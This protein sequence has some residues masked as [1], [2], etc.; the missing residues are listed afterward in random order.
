MNILI[1]SA[2]T[3]EILPLL[4]YL[5]EHFKSKEGV[6]FFNNKIDIR[7][8]VT[9][10]GAVHTSFHTATFLSK[11]QTDLAINLGIAGALD[12]QLQLGE[13]V[14]IISDQMADIGVE[15]ADGSFS[16]IFDMELQEP[17]EFPYQKGKISPIQAA[18]SFLK[19]VEGITVNKVHGTAASIDQ[20]K[21]KY[22]T[23][24]TESMEGAAFAFACQMN[25]IDYLQIRSIS[26]YVEPRNKANWDIPLAIEALNQVAIELIET[27]QEN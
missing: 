3:F 8:L 2:T 7:I 11:I 1:V 27:L 12:T 19:T 20:I 25:K 17:D 5:K 15:N 4:D 16:S 26:N 22:P 14:Q 18:T 24:A 6:R 23:A 13:V 10:V 9:G 21:T